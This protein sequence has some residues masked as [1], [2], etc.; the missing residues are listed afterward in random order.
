MMQIS[1]NLISTSRPI[2]Q[3]RRFPECVHA[4]HAVAVS[5][6]TAAL[7]L[8]MRVLGVKS[9]DIAITTPNTFLASANCAAYVGAIPDFV[10]INPVSY[11]LDPDILEKTW[12]R[13]T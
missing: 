11:N 1:E 2:M 4:K 10:D 3:G 12:K 9:G 6:G 8:A 5:N 7:H 13:D